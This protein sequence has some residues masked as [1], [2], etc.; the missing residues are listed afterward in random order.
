MSSWYKIRIASDQMAKRGV[1]AIQARFNERWAARG[2][3][4][5][6]ALL[7]R[8]GAGSGCDLYLSPSAARIVDDVLK[9]Y[10]ARMCDAPQRDGTLLL[11]GH[12]Q[13]LDILLGPES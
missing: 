11:T 8:I 9:R 7:R 4:D 3:P 1:E 12:A 10:E 13:A 2:S 5:D 6:A